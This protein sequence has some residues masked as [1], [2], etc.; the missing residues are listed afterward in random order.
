MGAHAVL[1]ASSSPIWLNC[2][3]CGQRPA[4]AKGS[5]SI[6]AATGT[7]AHSLCETALTGGAKPH[8][9]I[10]AHY[11]CDGFDIEVTEEMA[12]AVELYLDYAQLLIKPGSRLMIETKVSLSGLFASSPPPEVYGTADMIIYDPPDAMIKLAGKLHVLDF[13]YGSG[14]AIEASSSQLAFYAL[15]ALLAVTSDPVDEVTVHVVQPRAPHAD[16]PIRRLTYTLQALQAFAAKLVAQVEL[17]NS[18]RGGFNA[19]KW[20]RF[21]PIAGS[22]PEL[23]KVNV[24]L[25]TTDFP[26]PVNIGPMEPAMLDAGQLAVIMGRIPLFDAWVRS[27]ENEALSRMMAGQSIPGLKLVD[28]R[29][30]RKWTMADEDVLEELKL[31]HILGDQAILVAKLVALSPTQAEKKLGKGLW[32]RVTDAGLVEKKSSGL[33]IAPENDRREA[34]VPMEGA[35]LDFLSDTEDENL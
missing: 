21:C 29:A 33:T 30:T 26:H 22:C 15:G 16:G 19:G 24:A 28:K 27:V 25:A 11:D 31:P 34:V 18:G 5:A 12:D 10:G 2:A 4:T 17:I 14:V 20:C 32:K 1:G 6:Y 8:A 9:Q 35:T 23:A 3:G 7:V 13:K